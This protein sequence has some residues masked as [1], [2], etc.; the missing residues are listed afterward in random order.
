VV[1]QEGVH[2]FEL[3]ITQANATFMV[4]LPIVCGKKLGCPF[5]VSCQIGLVPAAANVAGGQYVGDNAMGTAFRASSIVLIM[6]SYK[7]RIAARWMGFVYGPC[8]RT[9]VLEHLV[10]AAC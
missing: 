3:E 2:K 8:R 6:M 1:W 9:S 7:I 4:G 10:Y 5:P